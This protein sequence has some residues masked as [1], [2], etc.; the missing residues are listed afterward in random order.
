MALE[1][2]VVA[3]DLPGVRA[4]LGYELLRGCVVPA[5]DAPALASRIVRMLEA[6]P[7][8]AS[9]TAAAR[10]RFLRHYTTRRIASEM[11]DFYARALD[12]SS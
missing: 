6:R 1:T 5:G 8:T 7:E 2:P 12:T 10:S 11:V 3:T 9:W 4:V